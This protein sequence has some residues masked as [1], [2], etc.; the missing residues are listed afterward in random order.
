MRDTVLLP[1]SKFICS[2]DKM[3]VIEHL[4]YRI[5][6]YFLGIVIWMELGLILMFTIPYIDVM[7]IKLIILCY[8]LFFII[9]SL[10]DLIN[11]E[12]YMGLRLANDLMDEW[13]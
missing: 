5:A 12:K 7:E 4:A 11:W 1:G 13:M 6:N 3:S 10:R 2:G 9:G 8:S